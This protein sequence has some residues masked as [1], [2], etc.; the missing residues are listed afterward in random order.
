MFLSVQEEQ[1]ILEHV[2]ASVDIGGLTLT[3]HLALMI[4]CRCMYIP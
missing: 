1:G 4:A 3:L 2:I